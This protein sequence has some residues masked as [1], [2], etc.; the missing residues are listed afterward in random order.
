[1]LFE[2]RDF[3]MDTFAMELNLY[4]DTILEIVYKYG[5]K[6]P[7]F[8]TS[9]S[10]EL[11]MLLTTKQQLYPVMFLTESGYIPTRDIRA[12]SFQEAV[13]FAK[14]WNLEGVVIRSQPIMASPMLIDLVKSQGLVCASWGD[15]N[16]DPECAKVLTHILL[17]LSP[18]FAISSQTSFII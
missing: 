11:C 6:R 15:L 10:P 16:D 3:N 13:R 17:L 14:K 4:L 1:M 8:F 7:M 5:G 12:I 2:A 18:F 9:F